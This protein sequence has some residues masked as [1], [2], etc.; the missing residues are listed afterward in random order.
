MA[1]DLGPKINFAYIIIIENSII[2]RIGCIMCCTLIDT[3]A[4]WEANAL[5]YARGLN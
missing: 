1:I 2:T 3:A 5:L 4:S